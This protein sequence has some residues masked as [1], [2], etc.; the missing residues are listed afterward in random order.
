M[1]DRMPTVTSPS[2]PPMTQEELSKGALV[3]YEEAPAE[4]RADID[5]LMGEID[6]T[7]ANSIIYF[8]T[9]AQEQ[10]TNVSDTMLEGVRNKD[11]GP[12]GVALNDMVA[13]LRG[14]DL[15]DIDPNKKPGFF[16]RLF[17]KVKPLAKFLQQ[18][19]DVRRQID[20]ITDKL[21]G[22]TTKLLTDIT[23]LDRLYDANLDY[24]HTLADYIAAGE[25]K[26]RQLDEVDIPR[27]AQEAE[28]A[29]DVLKAQALRDLR[30]ARDDLERR[31]HDLKLTRQ[32]AMQSLPSIRL[33]QENDKSLV[34]KI[35]STLANTVPLWRQQ[36]AM[37]VTIAR[38]AEAGKTLKEATDLTN[39]LL[40]S[41]A[42][43]LRSSNEQ[44]RQQVERGVFD[45]EA[46][47]KANDSL[48]ATIEDSLRIADEGKQK[49]REAEA[50]LVTLESELKQTLAAAKAKAEGKAPPAAPAPSA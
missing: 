43:T 18:Y 46:V 35:K 13:T 39:E 36:L 41:N 32:V 29:D 42:E 1:S 9:S 27:L 16:A 25:E 45:I 47:K 22:H 38:S 37:A 8:G 30:T 5:R 3:T 48:I 26:L 21:E 15:S 50:T 2:M 4:R 14:F 40:T 17:G 20:A 49:R 31:V 28:G 19:E 34:S 23:S 11:T 24:F 12:A 33:V 44:I 10:L 7:N 6:L